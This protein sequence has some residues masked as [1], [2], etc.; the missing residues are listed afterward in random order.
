MLR[1]AKKKMNTGAIID[2]MA[3]KIS[4]CLLFKSELLTLLLTPS[5]T[6]PNSAHQNCRWS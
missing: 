6:P 4:D 5:P 3:L 1:K 2:A